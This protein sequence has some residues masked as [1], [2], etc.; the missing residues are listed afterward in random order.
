MTFE[1]YKYSIAG[2]YLSSIINGDDSGLEEEDIKL[3]DAF[4]STLPGDGQGHFGMHP[5][6]GASFKQDDVSKLWA[7]C[8]DLI[9][10][11]PITG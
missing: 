1:E 4:F 10:Y 9:F 6:D 5:G 2:R 3:L 11:V 8:Y 7:D